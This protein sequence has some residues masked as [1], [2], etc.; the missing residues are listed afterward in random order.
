[1]VSRFGGVDTGEEDTDEFVGCAVAGEFICNFKPLIKKTL[2]NRKMELIKLKF[3]NI[4]RV[5]WEYFR[6]ICNG[7][8]KG[9][10][11]WMKNDYLTMSLKK[12]LASCWK[13]KPQ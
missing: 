1:M 10:N 9:A 7:V 11:K 8:L 13:I 2:C 3:Y 6:L 12:N 5:L 4:L